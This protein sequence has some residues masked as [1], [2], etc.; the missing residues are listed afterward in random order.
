MQALFINLNISITY[1]LCGNVTE[2]NF[3]DVD[4]YAYTLTQAFAQGYQISDFS[5]SADSSVT[6]STSG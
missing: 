3:Y 5:V 4:G 1:D 6:S 2:I